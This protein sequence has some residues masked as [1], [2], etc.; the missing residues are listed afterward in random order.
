MYNE[1]Y[2]RIGKDGK[3][4]WGRMGAGIVFTDG[5][6]VLLLKRDNSSDYAGHW[7][8]P[9]G[10]AKANEVPLDT[11]RRE[12]T[13]EC[14]KVEGQRFNQFYSKDGSHHFHTY[15]YSID[16]PFDVKLSKEHTDYKWVP[17]DDVMKMEL[18]PKFE[19]SYPSYL[20][21]IK[22]RFSKSFKEWLEFRV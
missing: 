5:K 21:A 1:Q 11:A 3:K 7:C 13:E 18:H 22:K 20:R 16:K 10:K 12:S 19:E 14:G 6:V 8:I 15:L 2:H 9:G 4:Y 17:I